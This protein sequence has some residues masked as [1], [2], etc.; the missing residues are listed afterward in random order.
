MQTPLL[1]NPQG[2]D[3]DRS[4]WFGNT[5][6]VINLNSVK[7]P[8]AI[9]IYEQMRENFWI[10]QKADIT[11]D[12]NDYK[13][14]L[15]QEVRAFDYCLSF[16]TFLDS[17]QV[18]NI[19]HLKIPVTAPELHLCLSEQLSQESLHSKSYQYII[20]TVIPKEK[21]DYIYELWREDKILES[22]CDAIAQ[23]YQNYVDTGSEE[24]YFIALFANYLLEGIYFYQG[25][26]FFY[27]L[28]SR[29]LMSGCADIFRW[30]NKDELSHV[31]LYQRLI[32]EA[33]E[34]FPYSTNQL[35]E[36]VEEVVQH[37]ITW[38]NHAI[39]QVIGITPQSIEQYTKYLANVRLRAIGLAEP[40]PEGFGKSPYAHLEKFADTKADGST[41][42]NFFEATITSYNQATAVKGWDW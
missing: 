30:I 2:D 24:D 17:I 34:V 36:I 15:P 29:H 32:V 39:N 31:R 28:A 7:Y 16:L 10:P 38:S 37:E 11:Q 41:K 20:E 4:I 26:I 1:F 13:V 40:Y 33:M 19:P 27:S 12:V 8:W 6:N 42:G 25:F 35:Y 21:R 9:D 14:L 18:I 3:S 23:F 5:T 22:R